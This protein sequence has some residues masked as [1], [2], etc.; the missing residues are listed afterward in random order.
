MRV[1][2][3]NTESEV[4]DGAAC[5]IIRLDATCHRATLLGEEQ[6]QHQSI[7]SAETKTRAGQPCMRYGARYRRLATEN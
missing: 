5:A 7:S 1:M 6:E 3:R 2:Q 4:G